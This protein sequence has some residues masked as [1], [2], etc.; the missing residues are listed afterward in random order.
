[1]A[2]FGQLGLEHLLEGETGMIRTHG[3]AH[4]PQV[5]R[6]SRASFGREPVRSASMALNPRTPVV[7]GV[8]QVVVRPDAEREPADRPEPLD[9][10]VRALRAAAEDCDGVAEGAGTR[11]GAA[12]IRRAQSVRVVVPLG[13]R[14]INPAQLVADRLAPGPR[15]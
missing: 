4:W 13:G 9:L 15:P 12:L 6:R 11:S 2:P 10:M 5:Y 7:V 1:M 14:S 8:G 3:D